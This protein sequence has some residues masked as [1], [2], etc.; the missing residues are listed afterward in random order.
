MN[1]S[2]HRSLFLD[3]LVQ[4]FNMRE[5]LSRLL[6]DILRYSNY[7]SLSLIFLDLDKK[8]YPLSLL[9]LLSA[10]ILSDIFTNES[11]SLHIVTTE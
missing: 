8:Y 9:A 6:K 1:Y 11:A 3:W 5:Y 2:D 10:L 7:F 4:I